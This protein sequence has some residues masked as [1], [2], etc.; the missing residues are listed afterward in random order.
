MLLSA[1]ERLRLGLQVRARLQRLASQFRYETAHGLANNSKSGDTQTGAAAG[2]AVEGL[3]SLIEVIQTTVGRPDDWVAAQAGGQQAGIMP[4]LAGGVGVGAGGG[5]AARGGG[6]FGNNA[7]FDK[8]AAA[9]GADLVDLIQKTVD[10]PSWDVNGGVGTIMYF[11][12]LRVLVVRQTAEA[13]DDVGG[14]LGGLRNH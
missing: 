8:A 4:A 11:N 1:K 2:P 9:N 5:G 14:V 7:D 3:D 10:P 12:N 13:Q 6:A